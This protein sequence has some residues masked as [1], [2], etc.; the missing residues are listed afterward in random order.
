MGRVVSADNYHDRLLAEQGD[1]YEAKQSLWIR[2]AKEGEICT[3]CLG[4]FEPGE[5]I[6]RLFLAHLEC[7]EREFGGGKS[8]EK[9]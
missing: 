8:D 5:Y 9:V 1:E 2:R 4:K 6:D 3:F 7:Y